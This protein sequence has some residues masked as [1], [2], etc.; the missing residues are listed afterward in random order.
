MGRGGPPEP[1]VAKVA[2]DIDAL[3]ELSRAGRHAASDY[4]ETA[5]LAGVETVGCRRCGGGLAGAVSISNVQQGAK[6]AVELDPELVLF[7]GSGAAHPAG[8]DEPPH[9]RRQRRD[10]SRRRD[11]LPERATG[12]WSPTSSS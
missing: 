4:L 12:T 9:P 8:R 6:V 1:E 11:G 5:A 10:G 2:P 3:L 7:D